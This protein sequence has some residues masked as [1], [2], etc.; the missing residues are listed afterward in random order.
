MT[1]FSKIVS[2]EIRLT[3]W[4]KPLITGIPG[5]KPPCRRAFAG[6]P[7]Q[8]VD[9]IF[10]LDDDVYAGLQILLKLWH[11]LKKAVSCKRIGLPL[12]PRGASCTYSPDPDEPCK[13]S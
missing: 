9:Y 10:D 12:W 7:E 6:D 11:R 13:R 1:I 3:K 4:P 2:G 5:H 8:E